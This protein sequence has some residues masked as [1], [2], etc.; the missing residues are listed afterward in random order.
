M[1]PGEARLT[2]LLHRWREGDRNAA[3]DLASIVYSELRRI[4]AG[5]MRSERAGHTLEPTA[6]VNELYIRLF[7]SGRV[8]WQDR[9]HFFA[10]AARQLRRILINY[11]RDR[12]AARRGGDHVR[13]TITSLD[14]LSGPRH[15]DLLELNEALERLEQFDERAARAMELRFFAGLTESEAAEALGVSV[16]T[17]K[18][19]LAFARA[20]LVS[21]LQP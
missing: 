10:V 16:A 18:R 17:L 1:Q 8:E 11:A 14:N 3:D 21:Q 5:Y 15:D 19:D 13:I 20:W 7:R 2:E 6:V 9:A 4:A 12:V